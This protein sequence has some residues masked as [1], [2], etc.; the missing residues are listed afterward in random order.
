MDQQKSQKALGLTEGTSYDRLQGGM[1]CAFWLGQAKSRTM[2]KNVLQEVWQDAR[3]QHGGE[4]RRRIVFG[5]L[6]ELNALPGGVPPG[7]SGARNSNRE[8][9]GN[10]WP[11]RLEE[12][13]RPLAVL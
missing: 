12:P 8:A 9:N 1:R 6:R 2:A 11:D 3:R 4:E 10:Y 5:G 7:R 13:S